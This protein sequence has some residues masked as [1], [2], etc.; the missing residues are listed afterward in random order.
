MLRRASARPGESALRAHGARPHPR[1]TP[2]APRPAPRAPRLAPRI[3]RPC[4]DTLEPDTLPLERAGAILS[5]LPALQ[6]LVAPNV[7][8]THEPCNSGTGSAAADAAAAAAGAALRGLARLAIG[9]AD[10]CS[11]PLIAPGPAVLDLGWSGGVPGGPPWSGVADL[12]FGLFARS[13]NARASLHDQALALGGPF[14]A[15]AR[16]ALR[17]GAGYVCPLLRA[18]PLAPAAA[19]ALA[20]LSIEWRGVD[21]PAPLA[22]ALRDA[23]P[24]L[25]GL[26]SLRLRVDAPPPAVAAAA[27]VARFALARMAVAGCG[28]GPLGAGAS[29]RHWND[30]S[31]AALCMDGLGLRPPGLAR[32]R[33]ELG[34]G[35]VCDAATGLGAGAGGAAGYEGQVSWAACAQLAALMGPW[36]E[37][38]AA[39][40]PA[41]FG[42]DDDAQDEEGK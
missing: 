40:A 32:A 19:G 23:L 39:P 22:A 4:R 29:G 36:F 42:C 2:C 28:G 12:T 1:P 7:R 16:L 13:W 26:R 18:L 15:A 17:G 33:L 20:A 34:R 6:E 14:P 8:L 11:A 9:G 5:A 31:L 27:S 10:A 35:L 25:P 3:A 21:G 24:R 37:I 30:A 38:E 41:V